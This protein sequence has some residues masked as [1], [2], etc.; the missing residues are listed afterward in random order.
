VPRFVKRSLRYELLTCGVAGHELVGTDAAQVVPSD[1]PFVREIDGV[2]WHRCLRCDDWV[3][4]AAPEHPGRER[5]ESRD[6]VVLPA[7]GPILRDRIVLRVI[8][9]DRA[10]HVVVFGLLAIA[11]F[12]FASHSKALHRDYINVMNDLADGGPGASQARGILGYFRHV[13]SYSPAHLIRLG[14]IVASYAALA[15][16]EMVGLWRNRRWAEYLT[17][18]AITAF[19]PVE[20]YELS[21]GVSVLKIVV[22]LINVVVLAYLVYAK[23]LF[24]LRGGYAAQ[25]VRR[26]TLSGWVAFDRADPGAGPM[27]EAP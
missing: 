16:V 11:L 23:R 9:V 15:A 8:A 10:I 12:T 18:V 5:V 7:R 14:L 27:V 19:I 6:E 4:Q 25:K 26:E 13:F 24:G 3:V 2:R 20:I 1:A 17:S 22:F 21:N